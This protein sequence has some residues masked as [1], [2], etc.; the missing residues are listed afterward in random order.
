M[1]NWGNHMGTGGW[2]FSIL[3]TLII[4]GLIIAVTS[5][6]SPRMATAA[7]ALPQPAISETAARAATVAAT[8]TATIAADIDPA[9]KP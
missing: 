9:A 2:I 3:G 7:A 6:P 8:D 5:G 4:I 1:M